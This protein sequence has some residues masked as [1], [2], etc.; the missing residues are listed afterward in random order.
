MHRPNLGPTAEMREKYSDAV[1]LLEE[2]HRLQRTWQRM[3]PP[4]PLKRSDMF[5]LGA[6]DRMTALGTRP[7]TVGNLAAHMH[8]SVPGISQRVS[9]LE[10]GGYLRREENRKDRR[11]AYLY[12][13]SKGEE[14]AR[15]I[16]QGFFRRMNQALEELGPQKT[17][18]LLKLM[19]EL[20][21]AFSEVKDGAFPEDASTEKTLHKEDNP[22][23]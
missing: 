21:E 5:L 19:R 23:V 8:Q 15:G 2:I 4:G 7:V 9:A 14:L 6:V 10:E 17:K 3:N 13:T 12:L 16:M 22:L 11:V 1:N 20:S 18:E